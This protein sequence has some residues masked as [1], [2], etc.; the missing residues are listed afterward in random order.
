MDPT[1]SRIDPL[2]P[3]SMPCVGGL[4]GFEIISR[5]G[6]P[7]EQLLS[8]CLMDAGSSHVWPSGNGGVHGL[9]GTHLASSGTSD[10]GGKAVNTRGVPIAIDRFR[11]MVLPEVKLHDGM[12]RRCGG[13][14]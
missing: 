3:V 6:C 5:H 8:I 13:R 4:R 10:Q 2:V 14:I 1:R 7:F 11:K 12:A 9:E